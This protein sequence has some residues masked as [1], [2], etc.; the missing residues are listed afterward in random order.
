MT[1][2][3]QPP[4]AKSLQIELQNEKQKYQNLSST[5]QREQECNGQLSTKLAALNQEMSVVFQNNHKHIVTLKSW[6]DHTTAELVFT[7]NKVK[8]LNERN[9]NKREERKQQIEKM[10]K[11]CD[12]LASD[13]KASVITITILRI[14][15]CT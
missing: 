2:E 11:I 1:E 10:Q 6:M 9:A 13:I 7:Q 5:L 12:Q 4:T 8:E 15:N 14:M 3:Q